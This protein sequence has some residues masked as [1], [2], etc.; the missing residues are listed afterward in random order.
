MMKRL[1]FGLVT[2]SVGMLL[3]ASPAIS[4][5]PEKG[6]KEGGKGAP[7]KFE[8]GQLFPPPV[9]EQLNLTPAQEKEI[10]AIKADVK[11]K[12]EKLLTEEQKK[13]VE[14]FRPGMGGPGGMGGDKGGMGD[15]GAK[16]VKGGEKGGKSGDKGSKGGDKGGKGAPGEKGDKSGKGGA[17]GDRPERPPVE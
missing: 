2:F 9:V 13:I 6:D 11:A 8:L 7:P 14:D 16:G 5:P 3:L 1:L 15:K 17:G 4:Q 12:L 10:D